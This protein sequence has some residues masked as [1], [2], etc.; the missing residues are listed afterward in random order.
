VRSWAPLFSSSLMLAA[1]GC[2]TPQADATHVFVRDPHQVWVEGRTSE[3]ERLLLPAGYGLR[4]VSVHAD[5]PQVTQVTQVTQDTQGEQPPGMPTYASLFR[6]PQGG[7]TIDHPSCAPWPTNPLSSKGE[8]T[9]TGPHGR[10]GLSSDGKNLRVSFQCED[11]SATVLDLTFVTPLANVKSVH[12]FEDPPAEP[13]ATGSTDPAL[14]SHP[15]E[16]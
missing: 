6:E 8:L 10:R 1:V 12:V 16:H 4:G 2:A 13:V 14:Q 7:I 3:G 5:V 15:W 11:G 9:V